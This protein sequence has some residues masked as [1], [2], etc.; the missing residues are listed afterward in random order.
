SYW[1]HQSRQASSRT[2]VSSRIL[3]IEHH[4]S[5]TW[6]RSGAPGP[7]I[8][9][10]TPPRAGVSTEA[11]VKYVIATGSPAGSFVTWLT[12]AATD[13]AHGSS[14]GAHTGGRS[15]RGTSR[16]RSPTQADRL[17]LTTACSWP[18]T[19]RTSTVASARSGTELTLSPPWNVPTFSVGGP[20]TGC[21]GSAN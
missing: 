12:V 17:C 1:P 8:T 15:A 7:Q 10:G 13:V 16:S 6:A 3:V 14:A 20:I 9:V 19:V 18:A 21:G 4:S 5:V 11:S 2:A